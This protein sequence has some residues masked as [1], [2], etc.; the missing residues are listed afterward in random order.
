MEMSGMTRFITTY[1]KEWNLGDNQPGRGD[2]QLGR[3]DYQI[4]G[5]SSTFS[6]RPREVRSFSTVLREGLA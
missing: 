4:E 2:Y 1:F 3:S 5:R 6:C